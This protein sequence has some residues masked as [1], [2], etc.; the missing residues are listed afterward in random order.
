[1]DLHFIPGW[2]GEG[3][4]RL[5]LRLTEGGQGLHISGWEAGASRTD[6]T[7]PGAGPEATIEWLANVPAGTSRKARAQARIPPGRPFPIEIEAFGGRADRV[8]VGLRAVHSP[9]AGITAKDL[10]LVFLS[11]A[12]TALSRESQGAVIIGNDLGPVGAGLTVGT[13]AEQVAMILEVH[14]EAAEV[15][16]LAPDTAESL[17]ELPGF[18]R[19]ALAGL[20]E[21]RRE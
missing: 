7:G 10:E 21:L 14:G 18:R 1:M 12:C 16:I 15:L 3:P 20:V 17:G 9:E 19:R 2:F 13:V 8:L 11:L 6:E 4:R 5:L